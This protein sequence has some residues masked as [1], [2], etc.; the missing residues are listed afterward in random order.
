MCAHPRPL[1][2]ENQVI[3]ESEPDASDVKLEKSAAPGV[4]PVDLLVEA[5]RQ[6]LT[7]SNLAELQ[8]FGS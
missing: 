8:S 5:I 4:P 3:M 6:L 1:G 2:G 7:S